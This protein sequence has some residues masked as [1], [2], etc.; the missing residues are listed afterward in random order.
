MY[1]E[2]IAFLAGLISSTAAIPQILNMIRT[3][4]TDGISGFMFGMKNCSCSLWIVFGFMSDTYSMVFWNAISLALCTTVVVMKYVI[5]S[6]KAKL[7]K[8][9]NIVPMFLAIDNT[10]EEDREPAII[11]PKPVVRLV[12][13]RSAHAESHEQVVAEAANPAPQA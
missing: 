12:Y 7:I 9:N 6:N 4:N 2:L 1:L 13:S 5:L 3:K 8:E 11:Q 10:D